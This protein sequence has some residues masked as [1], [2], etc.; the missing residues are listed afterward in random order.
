MVVGVRW[1][2][3]YWLGASSMK[4]WL[5]RPHYC[6]HNAAPQSCLCEKDTWVS[7]EGCPR[8]WPNWPR[9][10]KTSS[11]F[12]HTGDTLC[13]TH[14]I[15]NTD[16]QFR[17]ASWEWARPYRLS[18][19]VTYHQ[20]LLAPR[21]KLPQNISP[22]D[23]RRDLNWIQKLA[24]FHLN[25]CSRQPPVHCLKILAEAL[26]GHRTDGTSLA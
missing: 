6:R 8:Y 24:N 11:C 15:P 3:K 7:K 13:T 5:W 18:W 25:T 12:R 22:I 14:I 10:H 4:Y 19:N 1:G 17:R 21:H 20:G 2:W 23:L 9:D 26:L 16:G